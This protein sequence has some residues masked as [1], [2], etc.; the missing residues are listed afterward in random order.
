MKKIFETPNWIQN[1]ASLIFLNIAQDCSLRQCLT[2]N[3][4]ETSRKN[5]VAQ[6]EA[7]MIFSI[8]MLLSIHSNLLV[9][10]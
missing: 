2:S 1:V 9:F 10:P 5:F 4:A 6:N 8:L 7:E 3:R